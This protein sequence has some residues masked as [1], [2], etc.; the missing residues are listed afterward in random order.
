VG[1]LKLVVKR[2][3]SGPLVACPE[4]GFPLLLSR[5][6]CPKCDKPVTASAALQYVA[7]P[8]QALISRGSKGD[9]HAGKRIGH[10]VCLLFSLGFLIYALDQVAE[11]GILGWAKHTIVSLVFVAVV[12]MLIRFVVPRQVLLILL[13]RTSWV[14]KLSMV[15]TYSAV[16]L[17]VWASLGAWWTKAVALATLAIVTSGGVWIF[18]SLMWPT[19]LDVTHIF[20]PPQVEPFDFR[21]PQ[22]RTGW[23]DRG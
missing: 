6:E 16:F 20:F 4:C 17:F 23:N 14:I 2:A 8:A 22:G 10:F 12:A 9:G 15:F 3:T 13:L 7:R 19:T 18:T 11:L 5:R 1:A 21:R